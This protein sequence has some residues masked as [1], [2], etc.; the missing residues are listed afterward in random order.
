MVTY[1][2]LS[3]SW[4]EVAAQKWH[5]RDS[6]FVQYSESIVQFTYYYGREKY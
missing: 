1:P 5:L 3:K 2:V 6:T 4:Q